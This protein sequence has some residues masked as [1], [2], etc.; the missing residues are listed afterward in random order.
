MAT[1]IAFPAMNVSATSDSVANSDQ[2]QSN[3]LQSNFR[4][5]TFLSATTLKPGCCCLTSTLRLFAWPAC[6]LSLIHI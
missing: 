3:L 6:R 1:V 4:L 2:P 5:L